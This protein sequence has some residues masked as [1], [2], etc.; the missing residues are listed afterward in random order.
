MTERA[1]QATRPFPNPESV[2]GA[3]VIGRTDSLNLDGHAL[4]GVRATPAHTGGYR[5]PGSALADAERDD[6]ERA[7]APHLVRQ[8]ASKVGPPPWCADA[9]VEI[10]PLLRPRSLR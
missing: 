7:T 2:S 1:R 3:A 5:M 6:I 8:D 9:R 4:I 10:R